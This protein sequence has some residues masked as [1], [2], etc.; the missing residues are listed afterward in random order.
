VFKLYLSPSCQ[1]KNMGVDGLSEEARMQSFARCLKRSIEI[2]ALKRGII[3]V[4]AMNR[5]E[6]SLGQIV[7]DSDTWG[8]DAHLALH[9]NAGPQAV[10]GMEIYAHEGSSRGEKLASAIARRLKQI[11]D[12]PIRGDKDATPDL[13]DPQKRL[14][15]RLAEVDKVKAPACLIELVYHTNQEDLDKLHQR[16][17]DLIEAIRDGVLEYVKGVG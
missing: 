13:L 5:P 2:E 17:M 10:R 15:H 9:T 3:I 14:G 6:M 4:I 7:K 11:P 16:W 8:A 1:E 12:I